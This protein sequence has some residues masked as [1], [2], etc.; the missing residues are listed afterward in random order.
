MAEKTEKNEPTVEDIVRYIRAFILTFLAADAL[1]LR[2]DRPRARGPLTP[3]AEKIFRTLIFSFENILTGLCMP[4]LATL[5]GTSG[6]S[7]SQVKVL[8]V[9]LYQTEYLSW[10]HGKRKR[11]WTKKGWRIVRSSN[12]YQIFCPRRHLADLRRALLKAFGGKGGPLIQ[13]LI[14]R[15]TPPT[16]EA[17]AATEIVETL[18]ADLRPHPARMSTTT[19]AAPSRPPAA[20]GPVEVGGMTINDPKLGSVLAGLWAAMEKQEPHG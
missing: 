11:V 19:P 4:S 15:Y 6:G 20:E 18:A 1:A 5:A 17:K 8:L 13:K 3:L 2:P 14:A 10:K 9:A 7:Q 12:R 16:E